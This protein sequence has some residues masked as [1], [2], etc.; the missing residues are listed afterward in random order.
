MVVV[1]YAG[2]TELMKRHRDGGQVT[3]DEN[4]II[5]NQLHQE[6]TIKLISQGQGHTFYELGYPREAK[7]WFKTGL[8]FINSNHQS[9]LKENFKIMKFNMYERISLCLQQLPKQDG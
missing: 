6:E 7:D 3:E 2:I 1:E 5:I 8:D 4:N 9:M